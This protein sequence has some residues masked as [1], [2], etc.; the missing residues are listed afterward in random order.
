MKI[1]KTSVDSFIEEATRGRTGQ[2]AAYIQVV[3]RQRNGRRVDTG[4]IAVV[5]VELVLAA[6]NVE[7][8]V[9]EWR[10]RVGMA[11]AIFEEEVHAF[12]RKG[13]AMKRQLQRELDGRLE[14]REGVLSD[15]PVYGDLPMAWTAREQG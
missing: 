13:D 14:I 8:R 6:W 10:A 11:P 4:D 2:P 5:S 15:E 9:I 1:Y 7:G 3:R 12:H